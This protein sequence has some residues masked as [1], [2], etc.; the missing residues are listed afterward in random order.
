MK[1]SLRG[2]GKLSALALAL[3]AASAARADTVSL[4]PAADT[5][6]QNSAVATIHGSDGNF[7]ANNANGIRVSFLRFDLSGITNAITRLKLEL[8]VN[9][10]SAN[11][12]FDVFGLTNGESWSESGM[13]WSNA[14]GI[15]NSYTTATGTQAQCLKT[16]DFFGATPLASFVSTGTAAGQV[17]TV[18]DVTSGAVLNFIAADADKIVTFVI[19]EQD[20]V[21]TSGNAWNSREAA[22]GKPL[23][24]VNGNTVAPST[25]S[26]QLIKA[27]LV[28]GQSNADGRGLTNGLPVSLLQPQPDVPF[29][30]YLTGGAANG[31]GTLGTLTTLRPGASA[32]GGGATFGPELTFGRTLAN[33]FAITNHAATSNVLVALIKYAHGGTSLSVNWLANGNSTTNGEGADYV[34]FQKVVKAGLSRLAATYPSA[35]IELDGMIWVQGETD[36]DN[37][38]VPSAA[39]GTNLS[40]FINDLR[41][42]YATNQPYGTNLP[43]FLS[44]ISKNQTVYSAPADPDYPNYLLLRAGQASVAATM[45]N[46]FMLDTDGAQFST[47]T[48]WSSPG[49]HFD[50][51]GQQAMGTAFGQTVI[52][53]LPSPRMQALIRSGNGWRL[54]FAG[55]SG[56]SHSLER[57][58]SVTGPWT[59]LTTLMLGPLGYTNFDDQNL[60]GPTAFYRVRRP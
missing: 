29:Y 60:P 8:T 2:L 9:I 28:G 16:T 48:P 3:A 19:A 30:Y 47:L 46:V 20:P 33:Y 32:L 15:I 14:P 11:N 45:S 43:F 18:F 23:L 58:P 57:S 4:T 22:T 36:I 49:L 50:T 51:A 41:L 5:Y 1:N 39:Y 10:A 42:T 37:G 44:R 26:T 53:A 21:D 59:V 54:A 35:T 52:A 31:D 13:A 17:D 55:V 56:T 6:V 24:T 27:Y 38:A 12:T 34:I 7:I 40:R 25:N